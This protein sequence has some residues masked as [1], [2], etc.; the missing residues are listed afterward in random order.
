MMNKQILALAI[1]SIISNISVPLVTSV[2]TIL[3]GHLSTL[4]LAALGIVGMIFLFLYGTINFLRM[5]TTGIT[6]Q[7]YGRQ[8]AQDITLTLYRALFVAFTLGIFFILFKGVI[9]DISFYLMNVESLYEAYAQSYFNLRIYTAPAVFMLYVLMGWFFGMQNA[10]YPLIV[11]IVINVANIV[12]SYYFV[13]MLGWG[14][15]GAAYG[16]LI[17][18]YMGVVLAFVLLLRYRAALHL[19]EI[20]EVLQRS[21]L[22]R[23]LHINRD[24][25]IRTFILTF[26]F[27]FFYAQAAK[28]SADT[29]AMMILLLQFIIWFAYV[30]D[31][32]ANA[33]ESLVGK[34]YG[35][36]D[37]THFM[38]VIKFIFGWGFAFTLGY[39][40]LY[41]FFGE[42]IIRL[43]TNQQTLIENT[44]VY[45]PYVIVLPLLSFAAYV[46]DGVF[47]GM[48]ATKAMRDSVFMAT[49]LFIGLYY[50]LREWDFVLALWGSFMLFF[51]FRGLLQTW[52]FAR[53]GKELQ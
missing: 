34:Y 4:H 37:W 41:Y 24:I 28:H 40:M 22:L 48:T 2:D 21:E 44:V 33:A 26:S 6:A 32:F 19:V 42:H 50:A 31:G 10:I 16:T 49:L 27:A 7:A 13:T 35:A 5:G 39:M 17:A 30:L 1:P 53:K 29:L 20:V 11:T 36:K 12:F 38:Q 51:L 15:E 18:Q 46:W 14:I 3:M 47:I 45:L 52:L 9:L 25:F 23:F 43:H 8:D